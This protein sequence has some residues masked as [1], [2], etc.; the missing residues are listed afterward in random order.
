MYNMFV[1]SQ[2]ASFEPLLNA[3]SVESCFKKMCLEQP[4]GPVAISKLGWGFDNDWDGLEKII[5]HAVG[6]KVEIWV[7][8]P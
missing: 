6:N 1:Y 5:N 7:Y 2:G 4:V 3:Q 8:S